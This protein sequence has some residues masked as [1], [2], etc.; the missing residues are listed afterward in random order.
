MDSHTVVGFPQLLLMSAGDKGWTWQGWSHTAEAAPCSSMGKGLRECETTC[1]ADSQRRTVGPY[2]MLQHLWGFIH[3]ELIECTSQWARGGSEWSVSRWLQLQNKLHHGFLSYQTTSAFSSLLAFWPAKMVRPC[4]G[5]QCSQDG[6][7]D[8]F[9]MLGA[10]WKVNKH[11]REKA[12]TL[13]TKWEMQDRDAISGGQ[14]KGMEKRKGQRREIQQQRHKWDT[15]EKR[16][17]RWW[18]EQGKETRGRSEVLRQS[19]FA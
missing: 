10:W 13:Q 2:S 7:K 9:D 6:L 8:L 18:E 15:N 16:G 12:K 4:S 14:Q 1:L 5:G 3:W 17:T 11:G 19:L